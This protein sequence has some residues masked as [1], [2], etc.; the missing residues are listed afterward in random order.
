MAIWPAELGLR[1][2]NF[3]FCFYLSWHLYAESYITSP[4]S[5][6]SRT[7]ADG[8]CMTS[9]WQ[10][11]SCTGQNARPDNHCPRP[12]STQARVP[13]QGENAGTAVLPHTLKIPGQPLPRL[14]HAQS[15]VSF[16]SEISRLHG[17]E[18]FSSE[19]GTWHTALCLILPA[20]A[21]SS[22]Y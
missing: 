19:N 9:V 4:V 11:P 8:Q 16:A 3:L 1:L 17:S 14:L 7:R 20:N 6:W 18:T 21:T 13:H 12:P 10:I 2:L 22:S 5:C 15:S